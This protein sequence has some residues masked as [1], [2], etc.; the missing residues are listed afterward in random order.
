MQEPTTPVCVCIIVQQ[1]TQLARSDNNSNVYANNSIYNQKYQN[2][3]QW[4]NLN[5]LKRS[6][7]FNN[8]FTMCTS[9]IQNIYCINIHYHCTLS[10]RSV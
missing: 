6:S 2:N 8:R 4:V 3:K 5:L 9:S 10:E 7:Y 1:D